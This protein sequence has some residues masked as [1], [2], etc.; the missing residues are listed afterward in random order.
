MTGA[1]LCVGINEF[2]NLPTSNWLYGCVNDANDMASLLRSRYGFDDSNVTTLTDTQASKSAVLGA[3]TDLV[4][5]GRAGEIDHLV[6]TLS[7]HG[8]QV[9]DRNGDETDHADEAF[10]MA[11]IKASHDGDSWDL[12][13]VLVDDE[14]HELLASLPTG[15]LAEFV[16]DTCH[17]GTGL[18]ALD[19]LPG[20]RPRFLPPPT[21]DGVDA[22]ESTDN[23]G[24]RD[25]IRGSTVAGS[26]V[27]FAACRADQTASDAHF[28]G[29]YNGA[30]TYY[31]VKALSAPGNQSRSALL[32][33]VSKDLHTGRF[34]QRAQL[35]GPISVRRSSFGLAE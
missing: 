16:L 10:A 1:A 6:F 20:R 25:L 21:S 32:T 33:A 24:L 12:D 31:L 9:P 11:D 13:T 15:V 29:R 22:V 2:A 17:S 30:F 35:E 3:L 19:F 18:R 4:G 14:L 8:T 7:S 26:A 5:R 23:V 28:D 34:P 27:L